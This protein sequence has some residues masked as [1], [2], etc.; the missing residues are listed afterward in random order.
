MGY[1]PMTM[2]TTKETNI[3]K[4]SPKT[5]LADGVNSI[6]ILYR[7][8]NILLVVDW[9]SQPSTVNVPY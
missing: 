3:G 4:F 5:S 8:S 6:S 2:E 9:S 1:P 7:F